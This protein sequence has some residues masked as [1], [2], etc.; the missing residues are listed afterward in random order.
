[1]AKWKGQRRDLQRRVADLERKVSTMEEEHVDILRET[2][3]ELER[4]E[5]LMQAL[6]VDSLTNKIEMEIKK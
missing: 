3:Q 1:M 4:L 5:T 2:S 6:L